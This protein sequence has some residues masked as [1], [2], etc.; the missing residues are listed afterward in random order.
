[1]DNTQK[2]P[3]IRDTESLCRFWQIVLEEQGSDERTLWIAWIDTEG[4]RE[5]VIAGFDGIPEQPRPLDVETL[6]GMLEHLAQFE[7]PYLLFSRPG[8]RHVTADDER[9]A[10][11]LHDLQQS[12]GGVRPVLRAVGTEVAALSGWGEGN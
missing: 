10:A 5:P 11:A 6:R 2:Y 1:M 7:A 12:H 3:A 4:V 8:G 9:W